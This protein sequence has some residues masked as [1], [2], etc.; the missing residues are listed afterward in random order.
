MEYDKLIPKRNEYL[1]LSY[2]IFMTIQIIGN[3]SLSILSLIVYLNNTNKYIIFTQISLHIIL[4]LN[5]LF[6]VISGI[7][8]RDFIQFFSGI[9]VILAS[10]FM[11]LVSLK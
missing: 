8:N 1:R 3:F 4:A 11:S 7:Y 6:A 10:I 9:C 2:F 5:A